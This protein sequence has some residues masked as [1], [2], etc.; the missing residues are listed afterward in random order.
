MSHLARLAPIRI[1]AAAIVLQE[2]V[3][4]D[5]E[6]KASRSWGAASPNCCRCGDRRCHWRLLPLPVLSLDSGGAREIGW[7]APN[8]QRYSR[9]W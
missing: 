3:H 4:E 6:K 2:E 5:V 1:G 7:T 9:A 8:G